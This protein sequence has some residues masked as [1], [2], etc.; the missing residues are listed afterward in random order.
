MVA[1][2]RFAGRLAV[3]AVVAVGACSAG[4]A[5]ARAGQSAANP[6]LDPEP[7]RSPDLLTATW[8]NAGR[9]HVAG[10][11]DQGLAT[12]ASWPRNRLDR[13]LKNVLPT[14]TPDV[15]VRALSL[16]T[17]IAIVERLR[18]TAAPG[19]SRRTAVQL[20]DGGEIRRVG[21]SFHWEIAWQIAAVLA[22]RPGEGARA[23]AWYRA[24]G[25]LLQQWADFGVALQHLKSSQ[26]LFDNDALLALH[27]GTLHQAFADPRLQRYAHLRGRAAAPNNPGSSTQWNEATVYSALQSAKGELDDA[28]KQFRRALALDPALHEARIRLAHVL[29]QQ[30]DH[31]QAA[32]VVRPALREALPPFFEFY[33]ALILGR[34]EEHLGHYAAAGVAYDRAAALFPGAQS[35]AIGRSRVALARGHGAD[36]LQTIVAAAA[37]APRQDDPWA[38]YFR[39]H[40]V[41]AETLLRA[42]R[43]QIK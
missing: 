37:D 23:V 32:E 14:A 30:G 11:A 3:V 17:D 39:I 24:I 12:V 4:A 10:R 34:S 8:L 16:H 36:G 31:A 29:G 38:S 22:T 40:V 5:P 43:E 28:A 35:A 26:A 13:V 19:G 27:G 2:R 20:L 25:A 18:G 1:V 41:D 21:R 7:P 9:I 15:L 33:A 42:W 6:G